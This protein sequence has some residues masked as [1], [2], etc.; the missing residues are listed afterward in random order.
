MTYSKKRPLIFLGIILIIFL[1]TLTGLYFSKPKTI[2]LSKFN[3][4][5]LQTPRDLKPFTLIGTNNQPFTNTNLKNKWTMI[6]FGFTRCGYVCPT[7]MAELANM[8]QSLKE[9][10]NKLIPNVVMIS[11]D[12]ER[13]SI[14]KLDYYVKAFNP[15]FFGATGASRLI[16]EI[17]QEMGIA[18]AKIDLPDA[19]HT[20][21][22]DIQH[23]GA[24]MLVNPEGKLQA[25]FTPP[26]KASALV[27]DLSL[28]STIQ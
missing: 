14:Q 11:I 7:T 26:I 5:F 8:Y 24:V 25:F 10:N 18:Y 4:T 12:P 1:G 9:K 22:Y 28:L 2:D 19:N 6:F 17:T 16:Q 3:G 23:S 20:Q 27:D 21:Q 15:N 13:D